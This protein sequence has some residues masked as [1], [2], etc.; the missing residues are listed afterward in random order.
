MI[1]TAFAICRS[2]NRFKRCL[3]AETWLPAWRRLPFELGI[4]L[5]AKFS[6]GLVE[7]LPR[8]TALTIARPVRR[9]ALAGFGSSGSGNGSNVRTMRTKQ[10]GRWVIGIIVSKARPAYRVCEG[11]GILSAEGNAATVA[12]HGDGMGR[13]GDGHGI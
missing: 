2:T 9:F 1:G 8:G 10:A 11:I 6:S 12:R 13:E 4:V 3:P 5:R 7:L